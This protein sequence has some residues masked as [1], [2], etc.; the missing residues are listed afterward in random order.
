MMYRVVKKYAM[1][2]DVTLNSELE[3]K[4]E[5][6]RNIYIHTR[7]NLMLLF[8]IGNSSYTPGSTKLINCIVMLSSIILYI[9]TS[10]V[11][12]T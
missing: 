3:S 11:K 7:S 4:L 2:E 9:I 1:K 5:E 10:R 12:Y 8:F 6:A